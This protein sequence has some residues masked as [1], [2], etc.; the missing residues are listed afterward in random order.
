ME[1]K[2]YQIGDVAEL[3]GMSRD[4]LRHY[5]KRGILSPMKGENGYRYYSSEE[6]HRLISILYQ[7][8]MNLGL[9]D[10][11]TIWSGSNT[12]QEIGSLLKNRIHEEEKAIRNHYQIIARL[13][14]AQTD[15]S[16]IQHDI[17]IMKMQ[18]FPSVYVIAP[19]STMEESV[20]LWFAYSRNYPGLDM[21]YLYDEYSWQRR[22]GVL[23]IEYK[24]TQL[25]LGRDLKEYVDYPL[26]KDATTDQG[27][28]LCI[29]TI[30]A[31][32]TRI[33]PSEVISSMLDWADAQGLMVSQR[34]YSTFLSQG[35]HEGDSTWFLQIYLPVF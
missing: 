18:D 16:H 8:K 33:P 12:I 24:N 23:E 21:M 6:I 30:C 26:L 3:M 1:E 19:Q 34:F 22:K 28:G 27:P 7:R 35:K 9:S 10:I 2:Y 15:F 14:L 5:E 32:Q 20:N 31:S 4:T 17:G 11:E 29:S 25:V 13:Q